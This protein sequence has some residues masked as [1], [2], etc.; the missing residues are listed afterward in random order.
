MLPYE[1]IPLSRMIHHE[2]IQSAL[3]PPRARQAPDR[4]VRM[5]LL[6]RLVQAVLEAFVAHTR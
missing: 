5:P 2:R 4:P 1:N 3:A 6:A